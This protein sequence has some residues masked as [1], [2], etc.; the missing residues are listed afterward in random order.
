MQVFLVK[1]TII[2]PGYKESWRSTRMRKT[3]M[4]KALDQN[5]LINPSFFPRSPQ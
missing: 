1:T 5:K 3:C 2:D 4:R